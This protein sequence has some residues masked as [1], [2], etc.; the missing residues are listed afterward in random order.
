MELDNVFQVIHLYFLLENKKYNKMTREI[1]GHKI[2]VTIRPEAFNLILQIRCETCNKEICTIDC[3][4]ELRLNS[5][6]DTI[7]EQIG[8]HII[9][10]L[11]TELRNMGWKFS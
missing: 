11:E 10:E 5:V 4:P 1:K 8:L 3:E 2:V 9:D 7:D 6:L